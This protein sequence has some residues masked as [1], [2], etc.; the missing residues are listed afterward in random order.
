MIQLTFTSFGILCCTLSCIS[1]CTRNIFVNLGPEVFLVNYIIAD[2]FMSS[3]SQW[4]FGRCWLWYVMLIIQKTT[5]YLYQAE[6]CR[7]NPQPWKCFWWSRFL[8][9]RILCCFYCWGT[10]YS[11]N[12]LCLLCALHLLPASVAFNVLARRPSGG[13]SG[14]RTQSIYR[15]QD[16]ICRL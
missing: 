12:K 4:W 8:C 3:V 5:K 14:Q 15:W 9:W 1:V 11:L 10:N 7:N 2:M 6:P 13:I 16:S